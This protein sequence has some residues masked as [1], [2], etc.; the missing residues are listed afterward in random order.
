MPASSVSAIV[1]VGCRGSPAVARRIEAQISCGSAHRYA[2]DSALHVRATGVTFSGPDAPLGD[3]P[4]VPHNAMS[5]FG[6]DRLEDLLARTADVRAVVVGDLMLDIYLAGSVQRISPEAPV[7]VVHV[8]DERSALGGAA[9]VAA[10][11]LRLGAA[12]DVIGFVGRD[13]AGQ[14][15]RQKIEA[16]EGGAVRARL[17]SGGDRPTT[18]KT[19]VLARRQQVVRFDRE[20]DDDLPDD[21]AAEVARLVLESIVSADVLILEDY[22]KG[23][24]APSVIRMAIDGARAAGIPVVVDPKFRHIFE[25]CGATVFKPNALE[26]TSALAV[27]IQHRDDGWL[28]NARSRFSCEHLLVTLGEDGMVVASADRSV[29]RIP[30]VARQVFDVS[31]AGDTVTAFIA[32][33]LAAGSTIEE[34]A[35]LANYAAA[36]EVGKPGVATVSPEEVRESLSR[37]FAELTF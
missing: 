30:A 6:L 32:L 27:P 16:L 14:Q 22:N 11:V 37:H 2:S 28:E 17:V 33:A 8:Q 24:L 7:P 31:G 3:V 13:G 29:V 20:H 21:I 12:C 19:R 9:N 35:T 34:A 4:R 23:V 10:N 15:I 25:Y 18:T 26:L 36:I 1:S 5:A